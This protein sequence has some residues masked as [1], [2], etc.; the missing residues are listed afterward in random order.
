MQPM[1]LQGLYR[2]Y[3]NGIWAGIM[4]ALQVILL[5]ICFDIYYDLNDDM[6]IKDIVTGIYSGEP[7]GHNMQTLYVLGAFI[8]LGYKLCRTVPWYGLFLCLCQFGCFYLAGVRLCGLVDKKAGKVMGMVFLALFFWAVWLPHLVNVQYTITCTMLSA[9]AVFLFLT[10]PQGLNAQQFV[11]KNI[12]SVV[13]VILAYQLRTEMLLLTFPFIGMAGMIRWAEE[14]EIFAKENWIKYGSVLGIMLGG[15][16]VSQSVDLITYGSGEWKQFRDFFDARTTVYDFYPE[17][18]TQDVYRD[19]LTGLGITGTQQTLLRNY[20]FG[21]DEDIDTELLERA[22]EYATESVG[23]ARDWKAVLS[24]SVRFYVYRTFHGDDGPYNM[25]VLWAYG[26]AFF[27]GICAARER[28]DENVVR[29]YAFLWQLGLL[30]VMRSAIWLF[31]LVRGRDPERITHSLYLVE[32]VLLMGMLLDLLRGIS[33]KS[34][35]LRGMAVLLLVVFVWNVPGR[36]GQVRADQGRR[37]QI[38]QSWYAIDAYC[39]EREG[40]FYF[41]DVYSTVAFSQKMFAGD[42]NMYANYDIL[43]GWMCKSP[44]YRKKLAR[45][46][47]GET[48]TA[49]LEK[50]NVYLIMS[51]AEAEERG[52]DWITGHYAAKGIDVTVR[53]SDT[54]NE[55]YKVYHIDRVK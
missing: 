5:G 10:T 45:Y 24:K 34:G 39:R 3:E 7:D 25:I 16:L 36:V 38:N 8:S 54:I 6:M 9:T 33:R 32:F 31:I 2:K 29:R 20:N 51:D 13:L 35:V 48:D 37:S 12:P 19:D 15:M 49:L 18:V 44:L 22:A 43:G 42:G 53:H 28:T 4:V 11:V 40:N 55:Y 21:L 41:E 14:K 23:G 27:A 1:T 26:M 47:M 17:V 46:D 50:D 30:A 52:F